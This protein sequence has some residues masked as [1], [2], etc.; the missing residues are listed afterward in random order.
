MFLLFSITS[1]LKQADNSV[2]TMGELEDFGELGDF[3]IQQVRYWSWLQQPIFLAEIN[4]YRDEDGSED[5][6]QDDPSNTATAN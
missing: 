4:F 2:F 6:Q 1:F 3:S 5:N